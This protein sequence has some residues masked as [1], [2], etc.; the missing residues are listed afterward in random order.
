[1][2]SLANTVVQKYGTS[3]DPVV[4]FNCAIAIAASA[5]MLVGGEAKVIKQV[6]DDAAKAV[7][8]MAGFGDKSRQVDFSSPIRLAEGVLPIAFRADV[9]KR[10]WGKVVRIEVVPTSRAVQ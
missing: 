6:V 10:R 7:D 1:M 4:A 2:N 3:G 9:V 8:L 5:V